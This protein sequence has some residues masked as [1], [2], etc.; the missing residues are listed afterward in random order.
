MA[1]ELSPDKLYY[2]DGA[3]WASAVSSDGHWRWDG[4]AWQPAAT[5]RRGGRPVAIIAAVVIAALAVTTF[6]VYEVGHWALVR[7]QSALEQA[8]IGVVCS[9]SGAQPGQPL[10]EHDT[11]CGEKLGASYYRADCD[12]PGTPNGGQFLDAAGSGDWQDVQVASE[13][14]GCP[15]DAAADHERMFSTVDYQPASST[16]IADFTAEGW[17]GGVG[18][19][20]ACTATQ[21]CM[22]FSLYGDGTYSLDRGNG[23]GKF[24][25]IAGGRLGSFGSAAPRAGTEYRVIMRVSAGAVDIFLNGSELTHASATSSSA[26]GY[27]TFYV[28][29][30]DTSAG[31]SVVLHRMFVFETVAAGR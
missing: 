16:L 21:G 22:D 26:E 29:G 1:G 15:L 11:L 28:D 3:R 10:A 12:A 4:H 20:V 30:R 25:N 2:W 17:D 19:Q 5:T 23:S 7:T 24:D 18:V 6:G 27:A 9:G 14:L 31:E 8:G 13:G